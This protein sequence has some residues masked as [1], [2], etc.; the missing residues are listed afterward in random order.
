[1]SHHDFDPKYRDTNYSDS[2]VNAFSPLLI[3]AVAVIVALVAFLAFS[4]TSG[5]NQQAEFNTSP[6]ATSTTP[7]PSA[8]AETGP[9]VVPSTPP[10]TEQPKNQ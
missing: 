7:A 3:G 1:M 6:P 9:S 4:N 5:T 8:P 2:G 10:A